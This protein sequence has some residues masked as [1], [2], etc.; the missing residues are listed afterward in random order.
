MKII[1]LG[2]CGIQGRTALHDLASDNEVS[3]IICADIRF[4]DLLKIEKFTDMSKIRTIAV[5]AHDKNALI[6]LFQKADVV[7]DLLPDNFQQ[8]VNEAAIETKISVVNT[9]YTHAAGKLDTR[10]K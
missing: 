5:D 8:H 3:E 6:D 2:G 1:V 4:D 9:N 10:A 7:I